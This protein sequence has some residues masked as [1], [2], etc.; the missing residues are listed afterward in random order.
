MP[1]KNLWGQ[2]PTPDETRTPTQILKEQAA[3]LSDLTQGVLQGDVTVDARVLQGSFYLR[4]DIVAPAIDNYRYSVLSA[5][6]G[7]QLYPVTVTRQFET[8]VAVEC[9]DEATFESTLGQILTSPSVRR[10][11]SSLLAQSRAM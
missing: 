4:L 9:R 1:T 2:L 10:A 7:V 8:S 6:H 11:V 3:L 5:H